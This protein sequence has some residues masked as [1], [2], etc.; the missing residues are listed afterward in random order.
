[1]LKKLSYGISISSTGMYIYI[2]FLHIIYYR[3]GN[4]DFQLLVL[5]SAAPQGSA[6]PATIYTTNKDIYQTILNDELANYLHFMFSMNCGE[7]QLLPYTN[8]IISLRKKD[9]IHEFSHFSCTNM[10]L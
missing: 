4:E 1:M 8:I 2:F 3:S 9:K 6:I 7:Q 10:K 5:L